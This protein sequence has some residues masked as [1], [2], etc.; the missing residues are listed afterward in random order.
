[1]NIF[2]LQKFASDT[3]EAVQGSSVIYLFRV[4]ED[5]T[6]EDATVIAFPTE[7]ER[8]V[9]KDADTTATKDGSIR[10]PSQAEIEITSTSIL[11]KGDTIIDKLESAM[12]NDKLVE[13][14]E[15]NLEEEGAGEYAEKYKA[16]YYQGYITELTKT[17]SAEDAC[18]IEITY[19]ANGSGA[20]GYASVSADQKKTAS[21]VY[22][23]VLKETE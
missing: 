20:D 4:A 6:K 2:D 5:A 12:L 14:W 23:D 15:V 13:C 22:K 16:K 21:Y 10:T 9:S 18:E 17:S 7:N 1:M 3:L 8:T 11:A 19:G